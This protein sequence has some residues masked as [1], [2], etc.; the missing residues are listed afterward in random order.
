MFSSMFNYFM[1]DIDKIPAAYKK[2]LDTNDKET[3]VCDYLSGM[4]DRYAVSVFKSIFIPDNF[5]F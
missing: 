2:L 1:N 5:E 3:V 4:T